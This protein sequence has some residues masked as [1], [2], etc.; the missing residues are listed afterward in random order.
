V[1]GKG[2]YHPI[3]AARDTL[4]I[5]EGALMDQ[6][7]LKHPDFGKALGVCFKLESIDL[8]GCRAIGDDFFNHLMNGE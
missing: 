2:L 5:Y 1:T 6:E 3:Y 7:D 4:Q 8:G